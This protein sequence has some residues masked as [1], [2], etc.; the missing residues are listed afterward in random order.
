[1]EALVYKLLELG[2]FFLSLSAETRV[3]GRRPTAANPSAMS[4]A[5][6]E[7]RFGWALP[8]IAQ[9]QLC[10]CSLLMVKDFQVG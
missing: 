3:L 6:T 8:W 7:S 9:S 4:V 1:M 5:R 10:C 2:S